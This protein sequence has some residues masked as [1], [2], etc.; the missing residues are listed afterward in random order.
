VVVLPPRLADDA[1]CLAAPNV[2]ADPG[3]GADDQAG[4]PDRKVDDQVLDP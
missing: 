2:E 1:E 4:A 3:D